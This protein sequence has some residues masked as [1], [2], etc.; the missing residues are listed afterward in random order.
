MNYGKKY[1]F[2]WTP[3]LR[4]ALIIFG[5]VLIMFGAICGFIT[6]LAFAHDIPNVPDS[7]PAEAPEIPAETSYTAP[8]P[9]PTKEYYDCPLSE[10]LQDY[11]RML[12]EEHDLPM[13]LVIAQIDVE[14]DFI[15][16]AM[17]GTNDYGLMQI[18][19]INH[20]RMQEEFGITD[21][22]DPYQNVLCGI[23]ILAEHY[24]RFGDIDKALMAYNLGA[25]GARKLWSKGIYS[26]EYV[27]EVRSAMESVKYRSER[28]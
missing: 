9:I 12:C 22:L 14:S 26:T 17:S 2:R 25:S 24:H 8:T 7:P 1:T 5:A 18:N 11:I 15:P 28:V 19:K 4:L 16:E 13:D 3:R 20:E 6:G 10:E 27:K 23:N 21:F